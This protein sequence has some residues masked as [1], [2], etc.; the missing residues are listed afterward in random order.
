MHL[1]DHEILEP[2]PG[3]VGEEPARSCAWRILTERWDGRRDN[4]C[5]NRGESL[6]GV[7]APPESCLGFADVAGVALRGRGQERPGGALA[8]CVVEYVRT[9]RLCARSVR[10]DLP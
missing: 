4:R 5:R 9:H 6:G 2:V 8:A 3:H 7:A 10:M 1:R